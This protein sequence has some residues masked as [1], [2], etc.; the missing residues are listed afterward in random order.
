[1]K[2]LLILAMTAGISGSIAETTVLARA[3]EQASFSGTYSE[4][5]A[6]GKSAD[7]THS[8]LEVVQSDQAIEISR[9]ASGKNTTSKCPFDG[10]E[11]EYTSSGGVPGKCKAKLKGRDLL[12]ESVV[13]ARQPPGAPMRIHT[14]ERWQLSKDAKTLTVKSEVD[15]PDAPAAVSSAI[16]SGLSGTDK[17]I[18]VEG[19]RI[20]ESH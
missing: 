13:I 7:S 11:G 19:A 6:K 20:G 12:I 2:K 4:G 9:V 14:K 16:A 18:R 5:P 1:M 3:E 15:F 10:T 17:Y 8:T